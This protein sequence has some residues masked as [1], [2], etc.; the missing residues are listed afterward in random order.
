MLYR[1]LSRE[2][3][4][5]EAL[6]EYREA[7]EVAGQIVVFFQ[8]RKSFEKGDLKQLL[9]IRSNYEN[10]DYK[11]A[12]LIRPGLIEQLYETIEQLKNL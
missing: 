3:L 11:S 10:L 8:N 7:S 1:Q 6:W 12:Q 4:R 9:K 5:Q 2:E